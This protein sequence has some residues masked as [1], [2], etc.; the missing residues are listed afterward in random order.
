MLKIT[1]F[2]YVLHL[3]CCCYYASEFSPP[4]KLVTC[5]EYFQG[6]PWPRPRDFDSPVKLCQTQLENNS[7]A[8][9]ELFANPIVYY[10][11]LFDT[12]RRTPLY[13]AN[14]VKLSSKPSI[15]TRPSNELWKR[16]ATN[17][18]KKSVPQTTINSDINYVNNPDSC[19]TLQAVDDDY[20]NNNMHLDRGHLCPSHINGPNEAKMNSTF[21][22]TNAAPQ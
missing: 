4:L 5:D 20:R 13:S 11:T 16:V 21:T 15:A 18:C 9:Q 10:A 8:I 2:I 1:T 3:L 17:L 22:L 7:L 19:K 6:R 12:H 14:R